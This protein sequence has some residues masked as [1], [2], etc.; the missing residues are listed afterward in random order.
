MKAFWWNLTVDWPCALV[1]WLWAYVAVPL[2]AH[3]ER[4]TFRL[5]MRIVLQIFLFAALL[6]Y[7]EQIVSLDLTFLFYIDVTAYLEIATAVFVLVAQGHVGRAFG[8]VARSV[9]LA[10]QNWSRSLRHFGT[11]QHRNVSALFRKKGAA[12]PKKSDDE[13]G[14][15]TG[16]LAAPAWG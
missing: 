9:R 5:A 10:L 3:L 15:L 6:M 2:L 14:L 13:P 11:R 1:D 12:R 4:L 7:F 16:G 8:A